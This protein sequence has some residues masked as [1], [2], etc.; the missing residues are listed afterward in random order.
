MKVPLLDVTRHNEKVHDEM[1]AAFERVLTSGRF[2]LGPEVARFEALCAEY[3]GSGHA[4]GVSSGSDALLASLMAFGIGPG[5]E[6]VC[7]TFT[8]FATAGAVWRLGAKPVFVD[9]EAGTLNCTA[10]AMEARITD[11]TRVL[12]PV[13][14]F[15][16]CCDMGPVL[17]LAER[18]GVPVI[19]DAAQAIG[20]AWN[21]RSAGT[22]GRLGCFSFYPTKN[23]GAL[24]DGGLVTTNDDAL[25]ERV[26]VL[27]DHGMKPK[28]HHHAVGGNF[29]LDALQAALLA[30]K[31][32]HLDAAHEERRK[33][34]GRYNELFEQSGLAGTRISLPVDRT[35]SHIYNQYVVRVLD[36]Q[37]DELRAFLTRQEVGTEIYYPVPLHLQ[38]CFAELGHRVG[39]FPV[40]ER[41]AAEALA[42]PIFPGLRNAEIEHVV[43][44]ITAFFAGR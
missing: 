44:S 8:F 30:V 33:N 4:I 21:G 10:E 20:A 17:E 37:R 23:L 32:P 39:D 38:A 40:A 12:M 28:Y 29:R 43:G 19:E 41:A 26:R 3:I 34:A 42:L 27:L 35:G 11:R 9:S 36:G 25:A 1:R 15:G 6:V 31:L 13:H 7:P 16:Q 14:L 2:I 22:M 24:G 5:D 18:R